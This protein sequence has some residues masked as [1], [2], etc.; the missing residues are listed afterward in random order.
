MPVLETYKEKIIHFFST[1]VSPIPLGIYRILIA[2]FALAQ[3][4]L[5]YPD[6]LAFF[7][8][9]GWIQWEISQALSESWRLQMLHVHWLFEKFGFTPDQ[10]VITFF[11][12]YIVSCVGLL[13][14]WF[15][16]IWAILTWFC[17]YILMATIPTFM[18]GVDIFLHISLFYIMIMPVN[19]AFSL[20]LL[21]GRATPTSDWT[22]T[23][24]IRVLQIHMC[25]AYFSAG[26]EKMMAKEWW[27]GNVLWRS[28]VQ[29]DF[30]QYNLEFLA[31]YPFIPMVLSWFTMIIETFYFIAMWIPRIRVFWLLGMIMLHL[32]IGMFL[33]LWLFG[34]IMIIMSVSAFGYG[35]WQDLNKTV[36]R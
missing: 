26:Y 33:G 15:T 7:G 14:G 28:V 6:W 32:G 2:S 4:A 35:A 12:I 3:A 21:Q 31:K 27:D 1:P 17:H 5:W 9:D 25:L 24:S 11:W 34:I 19:K 30:R 29:P 13:A 36:P 23:L 16:R 22:V 8:Q 18:Y 20:D 10:T